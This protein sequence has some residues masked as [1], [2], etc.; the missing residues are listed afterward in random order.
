M[1]FIRHVNQDLVL[2]SNKMTYVCVVVDPRILTECL[3][4]HMSLNELRSVLVPAISD[5]Y[6]NVVQPRVTRGG[7][8]HNPSIS[9]SDLDKPPRPRPTTHKTLFIKYEESV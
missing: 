1:T 3:I 4:D 7:S 6:G 9:L 8:K 2:E 5:E